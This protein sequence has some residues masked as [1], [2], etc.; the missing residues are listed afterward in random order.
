MKL[1]EQLQKCAEGHIYIWTD[2]YWCPK[3]NPDGWIISLRC[4]KCEFEMGRPPTED[5]LKIICKMENLK[6]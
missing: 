2:Y 5:E 6:D 1:S 3:L 4:E